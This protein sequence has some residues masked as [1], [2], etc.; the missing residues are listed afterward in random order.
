MQSGS[1]PHFPRVRTALDALH[2]AEDNVAVRNCRD[3][4]H[5]VHGN[6]SA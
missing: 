3:E 2:D 5:S 6:H 4:S 1:L